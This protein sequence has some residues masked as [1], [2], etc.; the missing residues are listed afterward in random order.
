MKIL[1]A[2][3]TVFFL[4]ACGGAEQSAAEN[5]E[6]QA[7]QAVSNFAGRFD[8]VLKAYY[9]LKDELVS[10]NSEAAKEKAKRLA[11]QLEMLKAESMGITDD[12]ATATSKAM[13]IAGKD[14]LSM[15]RAAF[16]PL[17]ETFIRLAKKAGPMDDPVY[18][19][20]CPMAFN[21]EGGD[22]LSSSD[23]IMN[24]YFGDQMLHCGS[25]TDKIA[26]N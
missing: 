11:D 26:K 13:D 8:G 5:V 9:S 20:H 10:S 12:I 19:Q 7:L 2:I 6:K 21:Y 23:K 1:F 24:P 25:V 16:L 18:V 22:W 3:F 4:F 15:Q 14:N 17:S